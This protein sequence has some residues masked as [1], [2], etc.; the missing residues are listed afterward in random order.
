MG[1]CKTNSILCICIRFKREESRGEEVKDETKDIPD[2]I[3]KVI[4]NM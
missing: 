4:I 2:G 1:A 3:S